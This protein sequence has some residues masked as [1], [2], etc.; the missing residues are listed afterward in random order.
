[1]KQQN[2][3]PEQH[4][5]FVKDTEDLINWLVATVELG[6]ASGITSHFSS[7]VDMLLN[8]IQE[9]AVTQGLTGDAANFKRELDDLDK[10]KLH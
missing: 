6:L 5:K 8:I 1:M 2:R 4:E 3:T 9:M 7:P 10:S